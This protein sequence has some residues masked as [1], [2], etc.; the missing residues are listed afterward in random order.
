MFEKYNKRRKYPDFHETEHGVGV[1]YSVG[2]VYSSS[3]IYIESQTDPSGE[4]WTAFVMMRRR[5]L[6]EMVVVMLKI[7][8]IWMMCQRKNV[9]WIRDNEWF[10][11]TLKKDWPI[12][13][14]AAAWLLGLYFLLAPSSGALSIFMHYFRSAIF[15][16]VTQSNTRSCNSYS[17]HNSHNNR[18]R[19]CLID[20]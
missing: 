10:R 7:I 20:R 3:W 13:N 17:S 19:A 5:P 14:V 15:L 6:V 12:Q 4:H 18:S 1:V 16:I 2:I 8:M 9:H 11:K